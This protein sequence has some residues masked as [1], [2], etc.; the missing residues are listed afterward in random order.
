MILAMAK[1]PVP[2]LAMSTCC[3]VLDVPTAWLPNVKL[4]GAIAAPGTPMAVPVSCTPCAT[5]SLVV[6]TTTDPK[7]PTPKGT[8]VTLTEQLAPSARLEGQL[9]LIVKFEGGFSSMT[10]ITRGPV[11]VLVMVKDCGALAVPTT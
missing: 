2:A 11:P 10:E 7:V 6:T 4:S 5:P 9:L 8:N 3:A 1:L